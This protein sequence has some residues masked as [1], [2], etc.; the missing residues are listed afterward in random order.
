[1]KTATDY[2]VGTCKNLGGASRYSSGG[3]FLFGKGNGDLEPLQS[4][5]RSNCEMTN[6]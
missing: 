3:K 4:E 6:W 2:P 1:M 5:Y